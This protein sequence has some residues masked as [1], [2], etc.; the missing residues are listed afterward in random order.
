[1]KAGATTAA[2]HV[3]G[4]PSTTQGAS[5]ATHERT[6]SIGATSSSGANNASNAAQAAPG[7]G[8]NSAQLTIG[9]Y[10]FGMD[11]FTLAYF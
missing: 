2:P 10:V 4:I 8:G 6:S 3:G 9:H 1:M 5:H 7:A 11:E